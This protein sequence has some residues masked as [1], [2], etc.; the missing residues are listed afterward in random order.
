MSTARAQERQ[1]TTQQ[2]ILPPGLLPVGSLSVPVSCVGSETLAD[3][4]ASLER[5]VGAVAGGGRRVVVEGVL[6]VA[7][8]H[9]V[10]SMDSPLSDVLMGEDD[11]Y[12]LVLVQQSPRC[13]GAR[14][15][16]TGSPFHL[17]LTSPRMRQGTKESPRAS[18]ASQQQLVSP[19]MS[20]Q[21]RV[22]PMPLPLSNLSQLSP[23]TLKQLSPKSQQQLQE[24]IIESSGNS[25]KGF[26][27][28]CPTNPKHKYCR[29]CLEKHF[30]LKELTTSCPLCKRAC[31]CTKCTAKQSPPSSSEPI[32]EM[33]L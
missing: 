31:N 26:C 16:H 23:R 8:D 14:Q 21:A 30:G 20:Q 4:V 15:Q 5:S 3:F 24:R 33:E 10:V 13:T 19:R 1:T 17:P 11:E 12:E 22:A 25:Q 2:V 28:L 29:S 27:Y 7:A 9:R 32:D 6:D 18:G